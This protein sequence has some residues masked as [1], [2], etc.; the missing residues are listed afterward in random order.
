MAQL[1]RIR[2]RLKAV[3][4]IKKITSAMRLIARSCMN[5]LTTR[6]ENMHDYHNNIKE[7]L[8]IVTPQI[9]FLK[10]RF[11]PKT[12]ISENKLYICVGAQKGL[13]GNFNSQLQ[14]WFY[15]NKLLLTN[16][17]ITLMAV[18]KGTAD[19]MKR[20]GYTVTHTFGLLTP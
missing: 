16:P 10:S 4:T 20:K 19:F 14:Y 15:K 17:V 6:F 18:G 9:T 2:Q 1:L 3:V 7:L 13:C 11:L 12:S 8:S 5:Q